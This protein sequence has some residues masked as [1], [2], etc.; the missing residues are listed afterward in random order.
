[1]E[2]AAALKAVVAELSGRFEM[3]AWSRLGRGHI[4]RTYEV[5]AREEGVERTLVVQ[6]INRTVFP[7]CR[8]LAAN[9]EWMIERTR[10]MGV[11]IPAVFRFRTGQL[12]REDASGT[13]RVM[14][15]VEGDC[16]EVI[17]T[18][19]RAREAA[20]AFA[21][22]VFCLDGEP[23]LPWAVVLPGFHDTPSRLARLDE[24]RSRASVERLGACREELAFV[25]AWRDRAGRLAAVL[26]SGGLPARVAH[27][28]AKLN[29]VLFDRESGRV[30]A[31]LDLDTVMPGTPLYDLGDLIRTASHRGAED[32]RD[33][34]K[35]RIDPE[36][37]Q[38][39]C[40]G[41]REGAEG[42]LT[43]AE[44]AWMLPAGVTITLETGVRFLTDYL[45]GDRYFATSRPDQNLDRCRTQFELV[46]QL[47]AWIPKGCHGI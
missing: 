10:G 1:M 36:L 4:H 45:D 16:L 12:F 13:W 29:N 35:V 47:A 46:R 14:E 26:D 38:A 7:D 20:R 21:A 41:Y 11:G 43:G 19:E 9:L 2:E 18:P 33:L 3:E 24:A 28:D 34:S 25:E 22:F 32:E 40:E 8:P 23:R 6:R 27:H 31:V 42:A 17:D 5:R 15:R 37:L 44:E 30:R 39:L